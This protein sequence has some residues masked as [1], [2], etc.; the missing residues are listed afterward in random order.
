MELIVI[1][2]VQ[3]AIDAFSNKEVYIHVETTNGAYAKFLNERSFS[4][5]AFIRNVKLTYS[6]GKITGTGPYRIGLKL[7]GGWV[8]TE[9][10]THWEIDS[11]GRLLTAGHGEDGKLAAALEISEIPFD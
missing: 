11:K 6:H 2:K 7:N 10:L 5:G 1:D 3:Q 4:A 8:Y 9:G